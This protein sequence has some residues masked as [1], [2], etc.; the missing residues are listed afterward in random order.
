MIIEKIY[1]ISLTLNL[2]IL[3][4]LFIYDHQKK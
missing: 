3:W 2:P 1:N 4:V